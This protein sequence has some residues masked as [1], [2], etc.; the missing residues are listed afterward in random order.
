ML[1][2]LSYSPKNFD[3]LA[4]FARGYSYTVP[5][6]ADV[7]PNCNPLASTCHTLC[8]GL[9]ASALFLLLHGCWRDTASPAVLSNAPPPQRDPAP[10]IAEFGVF[11]DPRGE[12]FS[13]SELHTSF[14]PTN[15]VYM[16]D[17]TSFGWRI[18][19]PCRA[20]TVPR[21]YRGDPRTPEDSAEVVEFREVMV[22]PAPGD[23]S[24][25][26]PAAGSNDGKAK[27][28]ISKD[29]RIATT[30]DELECLD[31]WIAHSWSV[32]A[33]DPPGQ[34]TITVEIKGYA[35]TTFHATFVGTHAT[36]PALTPASPPPA[37]S[38]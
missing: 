26:D 27:T 37:P 16:H 14:H 33:H 3:D 7:Y 12:P 5:T 24:T 36:S 35:T 29:G 38:P 4:A 25:F 19:L 9:A 18:R 8:R 11:D 17:G 32:S 31:G 34:W 20:T 2:Q 22:L 28:E 10:K 21:R 23:W 15:A 1:C 13:G 30:V 6:E